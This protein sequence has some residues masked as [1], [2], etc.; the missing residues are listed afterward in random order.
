MTIL[1][2]LPAVDPLFVDRYASIV[3]ANIGRGQ[4]A[5]APSADDAA[6][7]TMV[8]ADELVA[9]LRGKTY[10]LLEDI[11]SPAERMPNDISRDLAWTPAQ[12]LRTLA[13]LALLAVILIAAVE[14]VG[15]DRLHAAVAEAGPWAPVLFVCAKMSTY[16]VAPLSGGPLKIAAGTLFGLWEGIALT[17]VADTLG[18]AINFGLARRFGRRL[19]ATFAGRGGLDRVDALAEQAGGWRALL[20]ARLFLSPF[21]D[22][23]SYAAGLG[24]V[25][26]AHYLA[27]SVLGGIVPTALFVALGAGLAED[28]RLL[29][30]IVPLLTA[31]LLFPALIVYRRRRNP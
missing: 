3:T 19:V 9:W 21:Y 8:E 17:L 15:V 27:V 6:V 29:L 23:I 22:F 20:L 14:W 25:K 18:G 28:R 30:V 26:F 4:A 10:R 1:S 16:V 12:A 11:G 2:I 7:R 31:F 5:A 24:P 13:S